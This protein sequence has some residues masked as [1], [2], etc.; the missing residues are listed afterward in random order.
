MI[1]LVDNYDSFTYNIVQAFQIAGGIV[2]VVNRDVKS[3][4][5]Q[6]T[7]LVIGPGPGKPSDAGISKEL[8]V[9]FLGKIPILGICLGHQCIGELFGGRVVRAKK[10]MHGKLSPIQ[11]DGKGL[12]KSMPKPFLATRYHSLIVEKET[13]PDELIASA[14]TPEGEIMALRHKN[15]PLESVQFHPESVMTEN[16]ITLIQ[17]FLKYEI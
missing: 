6:P 15:Y 16:G 9:R 4:A 17:N 7:H 12:F 5:T 13:L 2:D 8:I 11:H 3:I 14:E 1:L 10:A